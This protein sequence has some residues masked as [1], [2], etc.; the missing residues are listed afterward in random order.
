MRGG[1][2]GAAD[3]PVGHPRVD[4]VGAE[5]GDVADD[6][7]GPLFRHALVGAQPGGLRGEAVDHVGI[8]PKYFARVFTSAQATVI[9]MYTGGI[10]NAE[11]TPSRSEYPTIIRPRLREHVH[12][13]PGPVDDQPGGEAACAA[14]DVGQL[15]PGNHQRRHGEA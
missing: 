8:L 5:I 15:A 4:H 7:G 12:R 10:L 13:G 1:V 6:L 11:P 9:S 3:H 2:R 14:P